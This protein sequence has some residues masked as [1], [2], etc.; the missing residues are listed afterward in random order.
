MAQNVSFSNADVNFQ[1]LDLFFF[2]FN[3]FLFVLLLNPAR[4]T[5]IVIQNSLFI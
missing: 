1:K 5:Q 2:Q 3:Q 4:F